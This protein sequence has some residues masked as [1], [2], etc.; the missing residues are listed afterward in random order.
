MTNLAVSQST[1]VYG[2][3][4]LS[5]DSILSPETTAQVILL[6]F[7]KKNALKLLLT[8]SHL[9]TTNGL[10]PVMFKILEQVNATS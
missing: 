1:C 5:L 9:T 7:F 4:D 10:F 8:T 6:I 3:N 2:L